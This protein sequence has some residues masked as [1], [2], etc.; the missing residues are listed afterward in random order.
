MKGSPHV[1]AIKKGLERGGGILFFAPKIW[2]MHVITWIQLAEIRN[3]G[4]FSILYSSTSLHEINRPCAELAEFGRAKW[5][6][7]MIHLY[8]SDIKI[9]V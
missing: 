4:R 2:R 5:F 3:H 1:A 7:Y 9:L 6:G 8:K